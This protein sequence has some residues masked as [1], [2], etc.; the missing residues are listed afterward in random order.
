MRVGVTLPQFR[1]D[2]ELAVEVAVEADTAGV[3]GL[4]VFDHLWRIGRPEEPALHGA[5]LLGALAAE[6][7]RAVLGTLVARVG[8][9]PEEVLIHTF[10]TLRRMV[11]DRLIAGLGVGDRLSEAENAAYGIALRSVEER[12]SE[13]ASCCRG[14]R[15]LGIRTWVGGLA[16]GTRAVGRAEADALNLWGVSPDEVAAEA[17]AGVEVTWGGQVDVAAPERLVALLRSLAAAGASW[18]V[19]APV[20]MPWAAAVHAVAGAAGLVPGRPDPGV[21][22]A[23]APGSLPGTVS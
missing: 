21:E 12:W 1:D 11:G 16:P 20:G 7:R 22:A 8:L 13:L 4:F 6:T 3:D 5:T 10:A 23:G 2:A 19:V 18:A 17:A 14:L 15:R 9:V